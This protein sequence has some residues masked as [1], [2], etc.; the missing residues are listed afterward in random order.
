MQTLHNHYSSISHQ[1]YH[2]YLHTYH[3]PVYKESP[4]VFNI[5]CFTPL[6]I[7]KYSDC[8]L[9]ELAGALHHYM[10]LAVII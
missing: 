4:H 1:V 8:Y 9:G 3:P 2:Y 5:D 6:K 7:T 10:M